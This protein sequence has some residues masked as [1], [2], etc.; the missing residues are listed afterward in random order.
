MFTA[1]DDD[2][3]D[4]YLS[5]L[6]LIFR[7][8]PVGDDKAFNNAVC[9]NDYRVMPMGN[10]VRLT[11]KSKTILK[12]ASTFIPASEYMKHHI[13]ELRRKIY[14]LFAGGEVRIGKNC[15]RGLE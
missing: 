13:F 8:C 6:S 12:R 2:F 11:V 4:A 9:Q 15:A 10:L 14:M 7:H 1:S 3:E 5:R